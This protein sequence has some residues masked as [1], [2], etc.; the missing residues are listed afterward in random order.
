MSCNYGAGCTLSVADAGNTTNPGL[1]NSAESDLVQSSTATLSA[2]TEGYGIQATTTGAGSGGTLTVA[3]TYDKSGSNVGG[4]TLGGATLISSS[5][6]IGSREVVVT[7]KA[8]IG[9]LTAGG[10]YAD[11]I[12]YSCTGN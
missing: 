2:G 5:L 9:I 1:W 10:S 7:H 3:T 11:T 4:L 8:A 12:T 6:P